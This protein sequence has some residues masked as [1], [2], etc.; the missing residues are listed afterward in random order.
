M[1]MDPTWKL[2]T[3]IGLCASLEA[4]EVCPAI[5]C[6]AAGGTLVFWIM[7]FLLAAAGVADAGMGRLTDAPPADATAAGDLGGQRQPNQEQKQTETL[8]AFS[9]Y[10][11]FAASRLTPFGF[12]DSVCLHLCLHLFDLGNHLAYHQV[13]RSDYCLSLDLDSCT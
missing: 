3:K 11:C 12:Q 1:M 4:V 6:P 10:L 13:L 7:S 2:R 8:V 5:I 9:I